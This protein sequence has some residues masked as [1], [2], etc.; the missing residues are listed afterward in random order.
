MIVHWI[1]KTISLWWYSSATEIPKVTFDR[2]FSFLITVSFKEPFSSSV[3]WLAVTGPCHKS[4]WVYLDYVILFLLDGLLNLNSNSCFVLF[5]FIPTALSMKRKHPSWLALL[6][7]LG[8]LFIDWLIYIFQL[9][10]DQRRVLTDSY[11]ASSAKKAIEQRLLGFLNY[12][13]YHLPMYAKPGMVW[14]RNS[15]R[16]NRLCDL[17]KLWYGMHSTVYID[18]KRE[19][20]Y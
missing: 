5:L 9:S 10:K 19:H 6:F 14:H 7:L 4:E 11:V 17:V 15:L 13:S 16:K 8:Y 18:I 1:V 20:R 2:T 12:N 3:V